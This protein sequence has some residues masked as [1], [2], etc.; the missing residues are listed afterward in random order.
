M[1]RLHTHFCIGKVISSKRY[2]CVS[3]YLSLLGMKIASLL[4][5]IT[6]SV[7]FL[8][9]PWFS[10]LFHERHD[11]LGENVIEHKMCVLSSLQP[12]S[13]TFLI[14]RRAEENMISVHSF[15]CKGPV[16][17]SDCNGTRV[18]WTD[19]RKILKYKIL[20]K[21]MQWRPSCFIRAD[22]RAD[23]TKLIVVSRIVIIAVFL[24]RTYTWSFPPSFSC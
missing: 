3:F 11:F 12:L 16:F 4:R 1:A 22:K 8:D 21:S 14:L 6:L 2:E 15:S 7:A 10:T 23:L 9:L 24:Y 18:F 13:E 20:W 19:F 17:F 5:L